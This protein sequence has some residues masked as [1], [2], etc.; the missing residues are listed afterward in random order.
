MKKQEETREERAFAWR[1]I[2]EVMGQVPED[3]RE[4]LDPVAADCWKIVLAA[5]IGKYVSWQRSYRE[6][7]ARSGWKSPGGLLE[8]FIAWVGEA[9]YKKLKA[10]GYHALIPVIQQFFAVECPELTEPPDLPAFW[11]PPCYGCTHCNILITQSAGKFG[12]GMKFE[13]HCAAPGIERPAVGRLADTPR[14]C[15]ARR[16]RPA[17]GQDAVA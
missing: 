15:M 3:A 7:E 6:W 1:L 16:G 13:L 9:K 14:F 5:P 17:H 11:M 12:G 2:A 10:G 8:K 4:Q